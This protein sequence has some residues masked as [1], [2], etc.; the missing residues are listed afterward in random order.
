MNRQAP[1]VT[2]VVSLATLLATAA[3]WAV[4][5]GKPASGPDKSPTADSSPLDRYKAVIKSQDKTVFAKAALDLRR[6]I[7]R[8]DP[9]R[10]VFHTMGPTDFTFDV[11]GPIHHDG[12]Y[13]L[14]YLNIVKPER[15]RRGH[16]VS[17]DL[18]H[19]TDWPV[20]MWPDTPWDREA[21]FSGNL[22]IDDKGVPTFIYTGNSSHKT[23]KGVLARSSDGM[24][25]WKKKLVMDKPP[26]PGS[27]VHWDGQIWK[28]GDTW[29]Q[30]CGGTY[31]G[32]GAAV[33]WSSP[34]LEH[35]TYRNRIYTT[36]K[37]GRFWELPYLLPFDKKHVLIIGVHPVRYWIGTYDKKS[38]VFKPDKEEADILDVSRHYYAPNPHMVD[39]KGPG[40]SRRRLMFGWVRGGKSPTKDVPYWDGN[41]SIPRVLTLEDNK[42]VQKPI[43]EL[44]T[45]RH[46]H[47]QVK[48]RLI[49]SETPR[50]LKGFTGDAL[51]IVASFD[52]DRATAKRFGVKLRMSKDGKEQT[53]V[54]YEPKTGR[55][56]VGGSV[57][58]GE[59]SDK[60]DLPVGENVTLHIFLDRSV[61]E[62]FAAGRVITKR[63]YCNPASQGLDVFSDKGNVSLEVLDVWRMKS[64]WNED[65][66]Q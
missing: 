50:L 35:W 33:L 21:V 61:V 20:A 14:F 65:R 34:D 16:L 29:Y 60:A 10:P 42:L 8:H 12:K 30:L 45:L 5:D 25:T 63:T 38:L 15:C 39:E 18:V 59:I 51:E 37:Y 4:E 17:T 22:V 54:Y 58:D 32:G 62:V 43:P 19:W 24:L 13:H 9:H 1:L 26:Y 41:H 52:P 47:V 27:P 64:I 56:G 55:F 44:K 57:V 28:D 36:G 23:A 11:N 3:A 7:Q 53:I 31:S 48:D 6:W 49:E 40:G 2:F 46:Q 66:D